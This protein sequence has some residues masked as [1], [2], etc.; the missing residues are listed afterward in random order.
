MAHISTHHPVVV[1]YVRQIG[2]HLKWHGAAFFDVFHD[3]RTDT[4]MFIEGNP[5]IWQTVN[6]LRSGVNLSKLVVDI[7]MNKAVAP[8]PPGKTGVLTHEGYL[9]LMA[10]A[11]EAPRDASSS[12]KWPAAGNTKACTP[13]ARTS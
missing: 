3:E 12:A 10:R 2:E 1:E 8:L 6:G 7:S 4:A 9:M 11:M 13:T 5:R